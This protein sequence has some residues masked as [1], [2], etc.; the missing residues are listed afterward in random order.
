MNETV[1]YCDGSAIGNPGPGGWGAVII[2]DEK[3]GGRKVM[4]FGGSEKHTTNNR[5]ELT[6]S[7]E[8]IKKVKNAGRIT[9]KTDSQ[10][11]VN[12]ITKWVFGWERNGW[13]TAQKNEVLNKD[14]WKELM[15]LVSKKEIEW[16]H[17]RG[18]SGHIMNERVDVIANSYARNE[19]IKLF[20]GDEKSYKKFLSEAPAPRVVGSKGGKA[21]S[22]VSMVNGIIKKHDSWSECEARVKGE[23]AYF[24]KALTPKDEESIIAEFKKKLKK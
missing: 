15:K 23:K 8:G 1:I 10:Y 20:E 19:K 2:G 16:E 13:Q 18:H 22:Y 12:G 5:M 6:A 4:E 21:Y 3:F 11:L 7:I 17:V 24:K 9:I 14:L